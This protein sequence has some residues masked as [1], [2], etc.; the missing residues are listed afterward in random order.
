M[1]DPVPVNHGEIPTSAGIPPLIRWSG[2]IGLVMI[3][4]VVGIVISA[5]R[6]NHIWPSA[7]S[8]RINLTSPAR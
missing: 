6:Y 2:L 8:T 1:Y 7:D 4:C 3:L 5:S